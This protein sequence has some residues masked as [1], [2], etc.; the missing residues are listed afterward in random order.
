MVRHGANDLSPQTQWSLTMHSQRITHCSRAGRFGACVTL[1][2]ALLGAADAMARDVYVLTTD[3]RIARV[4]VAQ[5]GLATSAVAVINLAGGD[6]LVAIDVRPQNGRLYGLGFNSTTGRLQLYHLSVDSAGAR[7]IAVGTSGGF[8]NAIGTPVAVAGS[9]FG[10]DF[11]PAVDR[12]RVNTNSGQNFRMNPN[13]GAFIDGDL[14]GGAGSF[15]GLNMD[16]P[17]NGGTTTVDDAAYTNNII[18]TTVTTLYTLDSSSNSLYIQNPPN[19]GTQTM[20]V[21][22]TLA[23][24]PL[25]FSAEGGLDVAVDVNVA[26]SNAPSNGDALAALSVAG[27]S[28]LYRI[29]LGTGVAN[30]LGGFGVTVRDIAMDSEV[31]TAN[32][33]SSNGTAFGRMLV[34]NPALLSV[35]SMTG[36]TS[37]ERLIGIDGRPATG[38]LMGLGINPTANTGTLYLLDPQTGAATV[39]GTPSAIAF[40]DAGGN[41]VDLPDSS[42]GFDFNPTLDRVRVVSAD[43]LNFRVNPDSG[44][45]I[46]GNLGNANGIAGINMDVPING[47]TAA[48]ITGAAYTNNVSGAPLTTLYNLDASGNR[49]AIQNPPNAGT[50]TAARAVTRNGFAFDFGSVA[51]FDIPPGVDAALANGEAVG[52]GYAV[53]AAPTASLYRIN[54]ASGAVQEIGLVGNGSALIEGLVVWNRLTDPLFANGFE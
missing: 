54:L 13:T 27:V 52:E 34:Q 42:W 25:D 30:A 10:I 11:N 9:A 28:G 51:G 45:P 33:L 40:V 24:S 22:V 23:G 7:A 3:N 1:A 2:C 4:P 8:V 44:N 12:I 18:N 41:P 43:G 31:A 19:A 48:A 32:V 15:A 21:P 47:L 26:V 5:P 37:G 35:V 36:I 14:G 53:L 20:S 29:N 39:V 38:Q 17:I 6:Q 46:D 50:Q 49:L 16:G